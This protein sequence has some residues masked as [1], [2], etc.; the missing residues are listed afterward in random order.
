M[1]K[2]L[3][4]DDQVLIRAGLAALLRASG[5]EVVGEAADGEEAMRMT[6]TL[7]PDVI[8]MDIRMPRMDGLTAMEHI[9]A[10]GKNPPKVLVLTTFDLDEYVYKALRLG[11]GGF[12]LKDTPPER[13]IAAVHTVAAGDVLLTP[14]ITKRLIEAFVSPPTSAPS[15]GSLTARETEV[16][17]LVGHALSNKEIAERLSVSEGT[18]KTHL[19]RLM[20]K[21]GL[22]SRARLVVLSY[23]CGLVK[24][25][26]R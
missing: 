20:T 1:T 8:L 12:L 7:K 23:D 17:R 16:L 24:P 11:A 4:V 6:A 9:L 22:S 19:N 14:G 10:T 26:A 13:I 18:I 5:L 21:L 25:A 15:L 3:V 2:V